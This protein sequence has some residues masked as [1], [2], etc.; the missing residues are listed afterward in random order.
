MWD[1]IPQKQYLWEV[2]IFLFNLQKSVA[3]IYTLLVVAYGDNAPSKS[4]FRQWF[5]RLKN[6]YFNV[7][8]QEFKGATK[9]LK[10]K[11]QTFNQ[12]QY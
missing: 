11:I 3:E 5:R 12:Q 9:N 10:T 4:N 6:Y 7:E 8:D 2:L 1:F